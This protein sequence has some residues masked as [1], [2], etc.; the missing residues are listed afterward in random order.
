M[1]ESDL[2]MPTFESG[3]FVPMFQSDSNVP[4]FVSGFLGFLLPLLLLGSVLWSRIVCADVRIGLLVPRLSAS[5]FSVPVLSVSG[6]LVPRLSVSGFSGTDSSKACSGLSDRL[7]HHS[8]L[9]SPVQM[10]WGWAADVLGSRG[11]GLEKGSFSPMD[12]P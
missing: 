4:M 5:G 10:E 8:E 7:R 6:L 3:L 9:L 2:T 11:L 12:R 1:S